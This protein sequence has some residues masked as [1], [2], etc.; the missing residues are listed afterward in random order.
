MSLEEE[1]SRLLAREQKLEDR[2]G[3]LDEAWDAL[4]DKSS[5][6]E[7]LLLDKRSLTADKQALVQDKTALATAWQGETWLHVKPIYALR[8]S[9]GTC[10]RFLRSFR[11][12]ASS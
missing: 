6:P 12:E 3:K 7:W 5:V 10:N 8:K 2:Q 4:P 11:E 1:R 9:D